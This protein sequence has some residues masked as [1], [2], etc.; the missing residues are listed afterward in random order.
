MPNHL[1]QEQ[2]MDTQEIHLLVVPIVI[3]RSRSTRPPGD[4]PRTRL[5]Y[6][7]QRGKG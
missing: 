2:V 4:G 3:R 6:P 1:A 7:R 5:F